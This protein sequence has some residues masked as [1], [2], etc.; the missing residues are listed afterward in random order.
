[1]KNSFKKAVSALI[2]SSSLLIFSYSAV[3]AD[4]SK[5]MTIDNRYPTILNGPLQVKINGL[6]SE[7]TLSGTRIGVQVKMYNV[8]NDTVRVPDY[9]VRVITGNGAKYVLHSS[10]DNAVSVPPLSNIELSYLAKVDLPEDLKPTDIVWID[11]NKDVYPKAETLML[12]LPVS[13]LVWY[14]DN[15]TLAD[16]S[17]VK[18]WGEPFTIPSLD[19]ALSYTPVSLTTDF[20]EQTPVQLLKMLVHNPGIQSETVPTLI[21]DGKTT[22][23]I[24]KGVRADSSVTKLDPGEKKYIYFSIPTDLD[25]QLSSFTLS[26]IETYKTPN[27][28]DVSAAE[29]YTI[30]RLSIGLPAAEQA[31]QDSTKPITYTMNTAIPM[32]TINNVVNPN[33][34]ISVVDLQL[35]ENKGMGYQTGV[36]KLKFTNTSDKPLPVPQFAAELVGNGFSYAGSRINASTTLVVPGTDYVLNYSFVLPLTETRNTYTLKLMDDKT[37]APSKITFSQ[38]ILNVS[39]AATD[40]KTLSM[41]PYSLNIHDWALSTIAGIN[42]TTQSYAYNY[43]L[44]INMDLSSK[45]SVMVDANYNKMLME[46]ETKDGRRIASTTLNLNGD[47]RLTSGQ[48]LIYFKDTQSDQLEYPL[49]LK[50]Y[51]TIDTP[52]GPARK[53]VG[54]LQQNNN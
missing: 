22:A 25:T 14:G 4:E 7:H 36:A 45:E 35:F 5:E 16:S 11:V 38:V 28:T 12:D 6:L 29:T 17:A 37:A 21:V 18:V 48:Q 10:A 15:S 1:M 23:Q 13:N 43:K 41:Y 32:D 9:E 30:G 47:G 24:Y 39:P 33:M 46:L 19:S 53:L 3:L 42:Q 34:S 54:T 49:A 51:E 2:L 44:S 40:N 31:A 8:S 50:I 26:T 20:K 52:N 27:R